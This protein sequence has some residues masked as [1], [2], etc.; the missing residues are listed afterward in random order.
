M[1][2]K[3]D[4]LLLN[5]DY[6]SGLKTIKSL[7]L[8]KDLNSTY[9]IHIINTS[10]NKDSSLINLSSNDI[11]VKY[12]D[13]IENFIS[14]ANAKAVVIKS[15]TIIK[16]DLCSLLD[17]ELGNFACAASYTDEFY[18]NHTIQKCY[19]E[20]IFLINTQLI[21]NRQL[22][23]QLTNLNTDLKDC[24][25][26]VKN[27]S[28]E[29]SKSSLD[30]FNRIFKTDYTVNQVISE[31]CIIKENDDIDTLINKNIK[32]NTCDNIQPKD[33][34]LKFD[35]TAVFNIDHNVIEQFLVAAISMIEASES[36][37]NIFCLID[38]SVTFQD[39]YYIQKIISLR[40]S[41]KMYVRFI[42]IDTLFKEIFN[43][44]LFEIRGITKI[45]YARLFIPLVFKKLSNLL[46]YSDVDVLF[47]GDVFKR[48][49][50]LDLSKHKI[51]GVPSIR[52]FGRFK[53]PLYI[54]SGFLVFNM[55]KINREIY[56]TE[57]ILKNLESNFIFQDQ[58]ILNMVFKSDI[59]KLPPTF[60]MIPKV[61]AKEIYNSEVS[62]KLFS[63]KEI[64]ELNNPVII[65]WSGVQKPWSTYPSVL[66]REEWKQA[67]DF[68]FS[69]QPIDNLDKQG[70][71]QQ[72]VFKFNEL[73]RQ[74]FIKSLGT[75]YLIPKLQTVLS[76]GVK[77]SSL[78]NKCVLKRFDYT[79]SLLIDK[80]SID[81]LE[82][83]NKVESFCRVNKPLVIERFIETKNKILVREI[84]DKLVL[85]ADHQ[86][87]PKTSE[88]IISLANTL[89][90]SLNKSYKIEFIISEEGQ[91]YFSQ[92]SI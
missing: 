62:K 73:N 85:F 77:V 40:N 61:F 83:I 39:R 29:I 15:G 47:E 8:S 78:P 91:L 86:V 56:P 18:N 44:N 65:H 3:L 60:C 16:Q 46:I 84:D 31:S 5:S 81:D 10:I 71:P 20:D 4:I 37:V 6:D 38:E 68:I 82:L 42:Q 30:S 1:L 24:I 32:I 45:A 48:L 21:K 69:G 70:I 51:Y 75:E 58:D 67:K 52:L 53:V 2:N 41:D 26:A 9:F 50:S 17:I 25:L 54:N 88:L 87:D 49:S 28:Y 27:F 33:V 19:N 34:K 66:K 72:R 55:N 89:Y 23:L 76:E 13:S 36:K 12:I 74:F 22:T 11:I 7:T 35:N 80:S 43:K 57:E 79:K 59:G 90:N 92:I 14:I 63:D 64:S